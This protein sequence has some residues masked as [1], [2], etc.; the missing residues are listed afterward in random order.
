[1]GIKSHLWEWAI[2]S[3]G[4]DTHPLIEVAN[5]DSS[6]LSQH[7]LLQDGCDPHIEGKCPS[8]TGTSACA[9]V[10]N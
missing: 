3:H 2:A 7:P 10:N 9:I 6:Y 4:K 1:M 8:V 5:V